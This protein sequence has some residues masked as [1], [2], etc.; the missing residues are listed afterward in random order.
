VRQS[1]PTIVA[2]APGGTARL[3]RRTY[4][5]ILGV[6]VLLLLMALVASWAAIELINS[7]RAYATGEGRYSKAEKMAVLDLHRYVY[8]RDQKD[9]ETFLDVIGVPRGD[10][11]ARVAL[12]QSPVDVETAADGFLQGQNHT[13]DVG[14]MIRLFRLFWWWTPFAAA[15]E[16][17]RIGDGLVD[18]LVAQGEHV[19]ELVVAD[20][21]SDQ[22]GAALL[23]RID[24]LDNLLTERENTFSTHMGEAA[25]SAKT[26]VVFGLSLTTILLWAVGIAFA[27][28]L[29]R[30]QIAL[31]DKLASSEGRFRDY[32]EVASDWYWEMDGDN[33]ITY[34]SERFYQNVKISA[35]EVL[36]ISG[37]DIFRNNSEDSEYRD[38]CLEAIFERRPFRRLKLRLPMND[39]TDSY[40]F[41]S[42]KPHVNATGEFRGYRGVGTDITSQVNDAQML[43]DAKN[44]AEVAN[45]TKSEF[46]ANM[47][48]E[49]RTP[50]NA[51]L[52]FSEI[53]RERTFGTD[54]V[55][56]YAAYA[57]D[58]HRSGSHLLSIINDILD[59]SKIEAGQTTLEASET[60]L[61]SI[62]DE[63]R[64]LLADHIS[65]QKVTY[66]VNVPSPPLRLLV[67]D[68]KFVQILVNLLSNAFKFT[69]KGGT[70]TLLAVVLGDGRLAVTVRDTGIG[71]APG[72]I[73][74]ALMPF[75]QVESAFSRE[76]HGTGLGLPLANSLAE[77]HGGSLTI[78]SKEGEGT[79]VTVL[80]PASR[81][82][83]PLPKTARFLA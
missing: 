15:V 21:L 82:V 76:H 75:G 28:R 11:M 1:F 8:S 23:T 74:T 51:I 57:G 80:L 7:T 22:D 13:N 29:F 41:I 58:I 14:G 31:D 32:A 46:L 16:D 45:H 65:Q 43:M 68:R 47:S 78:E 17:W 70:V 6:F 38:A 30:Q 63:V 50:L 10:H 71:I 40:W 53:I 66:I 67:D 4:A 37:I 19:H 9:Y 61:D 69:P 83:A 27:I 48:H 77:L 64:T 34:V 12:S 55:D 35:G 81:V 79:A 59:L 62:V 73:E 42:G 3:Q 5:I 18:E 20:R 39:G 36:D 24:A 26:L 60:G 33:R 49:L 54:A 25:R 2:I 52:G 56:R 72:D 44:H